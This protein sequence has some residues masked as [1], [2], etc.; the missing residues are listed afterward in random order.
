MS[1]RVSEVGVCRVS[2]DTLIIMIRVL[3]CYGENRAEGR[4]R[5]ERKRMEEWW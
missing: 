5:M 4:I 2:A 1:G 3:Y